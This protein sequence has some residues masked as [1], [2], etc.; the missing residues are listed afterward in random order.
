MTAIAHPI[1]SSL[2]SKPTKR[3]ERLYV[4]LLGS[5]LVCYLSFLVCWWPHGA[6]A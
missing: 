4:V 6:G 1:R 5:A 2:A 3:F